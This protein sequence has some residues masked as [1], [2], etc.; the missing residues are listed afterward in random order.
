MEWTIALVANNQKDF[1]D[2]NLFGQKYFHF[3]FSVF[4]SQKLTMAFCNI[5]SKYLSF[6]NLIF[7]VATCT[8]VYVNVKV[9]SNP[10]RSLVVY[11]QLS[12]LVI[13]IVVGFLLGNGSAVSDIFDELDSGLKALQMT[14]VA[15]GV[16]I[17]VAGL[18]G[19]CGVIQES[20]V[21]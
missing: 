14:L 9:R 6:F 10:W 21:S 19:C 3:T 11:L 17:F 2:P 4:R 16:V 5:P 12:G 1:G 8:L 13:I 15:I 18:S 20:S 7:A